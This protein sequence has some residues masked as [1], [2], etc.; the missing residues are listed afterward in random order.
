MSV[1]SP[2]SLSPAAPSTAEAKAVPAPGPQLVPTASRPVP[3]AQQKKAGHS[4]LWWVI[5][6]IVLLAVAGAA[7]EA[8]R[9][10]RAKP[11]VRYVTAPVTRGALI[12]TVT[13]SG[14]I[15][16]V[17]TIQVGTYVSG[18]IEHLYCDYNTQVRQGQL[19]AEIDPRPYQ[20]VVDQNKATLSTARA[21]L[22]K[23]QTS[24]GY[25]K[26]TLDRTA[27]LRQRGI[28]SQDTLDVAKS[29]YDQ[30]ASQVELDKAAIEQH[31]AEL[32]AA[33]INLGY[34]NIV[35]P[36]DGTV[37]SRN[38]TVGQ[39]VAASFQTPTLFLIAT[40]L[41]KMQV[42]ANVSESDIGGVVVG[43]DATFTV[44]AFP[45][46]P[47]EGKVT[48]V[49]QAPQTVQNVV[50]YDVVITAENPDLLLKPGM[51]ATV[52]IVVDRRDDVVRL[53]DQALRYVPGGQTVAPAP[54][55]T[56]NPPAQ[57]W[58][59]RDGRPM[60][61]RITAGLDDDANVEV[62]QGDLNPGDQVITGEQSGGSSP[63]RPPLFRL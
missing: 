11:T 26:L 43:K 8:W 2:A 45:N 15:N 19:C 54:S 32:D 10:S 41:K 7:V 52:G 20:T 46:H 28:V 37:V 29:T 33:N 21:Q 1:S 42:D 40:D 61:V 48:Q 31:Q 23:D 36:V 27:S 14:S 50:T 49:R 51:T 6:T 60:A 13:A 62:V 58:I 53:P 9:E 57:A 16:P 25:A 56:T 39:T 55:P 17:I 34:T 22:A 44:E 24:L 18:V 38:V 47:F 30:A 3:A 5:V 35:S 59:L 4:R 12:R 63:S